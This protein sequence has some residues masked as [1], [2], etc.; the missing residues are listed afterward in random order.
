MEMPVELPLDRGS[1]ECLG[2]HECDVRTHPSGVVEKPDGGTLGEWRVTDAEIAVLAEISERQ[3][4]V[5]DYPW[6]FRRDVNPETLIFGQEIVER[7]LTGR[8]LQPTSD[9]AEAG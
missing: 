8:W 5:L 7:A 9:I 2:D 4:I 1:R 6:R 3:E